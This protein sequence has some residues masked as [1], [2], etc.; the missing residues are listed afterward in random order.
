MASSINKGFYS[1]EANSKTLKE[2]NSLGNV[3][4]PINMFY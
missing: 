1:Y 2:Y 4:R 3:I